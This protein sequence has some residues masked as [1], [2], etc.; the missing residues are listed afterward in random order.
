MIIIGA[1]CLSLAAADHRGHNLASFNKAK[2]TWAVADGGGAKQ[3]SNAF[4]TGPVSLTFNA[5][6]TASPTSFVLPMALSTTFV[7]LADTGG[8]VAEC[9]P[10]AAGRRGAR[11]DSAHSQ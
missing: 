9:A 4:T 11:S 7:A 1:I 2:I 8:D 5:G 6:P 3:F 10:R